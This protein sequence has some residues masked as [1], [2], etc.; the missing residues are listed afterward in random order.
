MASTSKEN[1]K[2]CP[3]NGT[4]KDVETTTRESRF[5]STPTENIITVT[6]MGI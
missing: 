2:H 3:V 4:A 5:V 1:I 6:Q